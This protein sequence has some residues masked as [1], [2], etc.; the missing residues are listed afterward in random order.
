M[1]SRSAPSGRSWERWIAPGDPSDVSQIDK[2]LRYDQTLENHLRDLGDVDDLD[3]FFDS[4]DS[5]VQTE[6]YVWRERRGRGDTRSW[7]SPSHWAS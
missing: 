3:R 5:Y 2:V 7:V 4:E 6:Y 1:A